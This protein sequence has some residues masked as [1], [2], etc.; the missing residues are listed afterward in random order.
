MIMKYAAVILSWAVAYTSPTAACQPIPASAKTYS[1]PAYFK[2]ANDV[3]S[4]D[5]QGRMVLVPPSGA[6]DGT[7]HLIPGSGQFRVWTIESHTF[8]KATVCASF[9]FPDDAK[10][11]STAGAGG[12]F[13]RVSDRDFYHAQAK[14][15]GSLL[16]SRLNGNSG[17]TETL[18]KEKDSSNVRQNAS[19]EIEAVVGGDQAEIFV[20]GKSVAVFHAQPPAAW[21]AGIYAEADN[22]LSTDPH[23]WRYIWTFN[24]VVVVERP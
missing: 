22:W 12:V 2:A 8:T 9:E 13:W 17:W 4:W 20:N 21:T 24:N 11:G 23:P 1:G 3:G 18:L 5:S 15:N 16:I 19:N 14:A 7:G 6:F 10:Q